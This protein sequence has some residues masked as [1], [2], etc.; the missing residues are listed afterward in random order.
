M[1]NPS[2]QNENKLI[3]NRILSNDILI[4]NKLN[5]KQERNSFGTYKIQNELSDYKKLLFLLVIIHN[6]IIKK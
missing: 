3:N 4:I 2:F 6:I 5:F 1:G